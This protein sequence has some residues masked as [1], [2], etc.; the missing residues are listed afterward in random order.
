MI[1]KSNILCKECKYVKQDI[2]N[3]FAKKICLNIWFDVLKKIEYNN[4]I[5]ELYIYIYIIYGYSILYY[6]WYIIYYILELYY[7]NYMY[8]Y[9]IILQ[10]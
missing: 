9:N 10:K 5:V 7:M 6:I 1:R 3:T 2:S 4:N 8:I